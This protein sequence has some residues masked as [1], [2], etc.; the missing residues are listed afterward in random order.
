MNTS[1]AA[2]VLR[3]Y[4]E[5]RRGEAPYPAT[6]KEVGEAIDLAVA[7][8]NAAIPKNVRRFRFGSVTYDVFPFEDK[9]KVVKNGWQTAFTDD[10]FI[11]DYCD[12]EQARILRNS[13]SYRQN[14]IKA[15]HMAVALFNKQK[16][17]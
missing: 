5:Y 13:E 12:A 1:E 8:I 15:K 11:Y 17:Q 4:N 9:F 3:Q 7:F 16:K 6:A 10:S 2:E 14:Y